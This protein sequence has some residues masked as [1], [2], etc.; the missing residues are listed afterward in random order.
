MTP[1]LSFCTDSGA[2]VPAEGRL[3]LDSGLLHSP[4]YFL[5]SLFPI[6]PSQSEKLLCSRLRLLP[7]L[8]CP[9]MNLT[10]LVPSVFCNFVWILFP[11]LFLGVST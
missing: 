7:A 9:H 8:P 5:L 2:L 6:L 4:E 11:A 10:L 3:G 1:V